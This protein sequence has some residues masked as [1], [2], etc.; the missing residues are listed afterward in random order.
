[1]TLVAS[2]I[3]AYGLANVIHEFLGHGG[4]CVAVP[5]G[6]RCS[7]QCR[8]CGSRSEPKILSS[9]TSRSR[10]RWYPGGRNQCQWSSRASDVD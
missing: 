2:A 6:I 9:S 4:I 7:T 1:M 10:P 3:V 8:Q 5:R